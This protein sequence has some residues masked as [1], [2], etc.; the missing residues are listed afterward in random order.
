MSRIQTSTTVYHGRIS[1]SCNVPGVSLDLF[2]TIF[3][4][5][6]LDFHVTFTICLMVQLR[7]KNITP[8][9]SLLFSLFPEEDQLN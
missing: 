6:A 5:M 4:I 1:S 3:F 9:F 2:T 8:S 7:D